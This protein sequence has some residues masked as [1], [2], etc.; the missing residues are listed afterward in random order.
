MKLTDKRFWTID[1]IIYWG[2][3]ILLYIYIKAYTAFLALVS[4]WWKFC[5]FA[6]I[7]LIIMAFFYLRHKQLRIID[8]IKR[9][10]VIALCG[11]NFIYGYAYM[12]TDKQEIEIVNV[13]LKGYSIIRID[14]VLFSYEGYKFQRY[15]TLTQAIKEYGDNLSEKCEVQLSLSPAFP[16]LYY[17]NYIDIVGKTQEVKSE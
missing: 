13:P 15:I 1:N 3:V 14:H 17:I 9:A 4:P 12:K 5:L 6:I 10:T 8:A 2:I 11:L 7:L 16:N